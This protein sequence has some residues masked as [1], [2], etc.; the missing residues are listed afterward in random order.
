ML[1]TINTLLSGTWREIG[2]VAGI[3]FAILLT[4]ARTRKSGRQAEKV[5]QL[6]RNARAVRTRRKVEREI[7]DSGGSTAA[8]RLRERWSRD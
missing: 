6:E 1:T 7:R 8:E 3:V 2:L 4:L 5:E